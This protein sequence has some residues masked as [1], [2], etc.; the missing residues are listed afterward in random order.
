MLSTILLPFG[1]YLGYKI[2]NGKIRKPCLKINALVSIGLIMIF[3]LILMGI[4]KITL[5]YLKSEN[6]MKQLICNSMIASAITLILFAL[7]GETYAVIM[8]F[9]LFIIKIFLIGQMIQPR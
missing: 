7:A 4:A 8:I 5:I 9:L 3:T 2:F 6:F 1:T